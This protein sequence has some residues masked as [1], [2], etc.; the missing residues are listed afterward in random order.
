MLTVLVTQIVM[1]ILICGL[2]ACARLLWHQ[3]RQL[4]SMATYNY[5]EDAIE[6]T[7]MGFLYFDSRDKLRKTNAMARQMLPAL[8]DDD[9][10]LNTVDAFLDFV[11]S[12]RYS[13]RFGNELQAS[14]YQEHVFTHDF[15]E[16]MAYED[17]IYLMQASHSQGAALVVFLTDV[18]DIRMRELR[19]QQT[20][21]LE[22]LGRLAGGVA[23]DFNNLISI[24]DGYAR[25]IEKSAY[26]DHD[27][28]TEYAQRIRKAAE[29]GAGLTKQMLL[30]GQHKMVE[31]EPIDLAEVLAQLGKLLEPILD[32][33][34]ILSLDFEEGV[35]V[36]CS[37]DAMTQILMN[38][39]IN[40]RD[41]MPDGGRIKVTT[42][43][44]N[45]KSMPAHFVGA[46]KGR[47][48]VCI[49]VADNGTGITEQVKRRMFE[50]FFT[51]KSQ[52]QGAG[53]GLSM[54][55]GLVK[56]MSGFI[57]VETEEGKGTTLRLY[58]PVCVSKRKTTAREDTDGNETYRFDGYTV[59]LA[60]DEPDLRALTQV[61]LEE[62]GFAVLMAENGNQ[63]LVKQD[64]FDD[65][66]AFLI[67]DV[68]MP[69]LNGIQL[70][71]LFSAI[72]PETRI[73]YLSAFPANG[74]LSKLE[75]PEGSNLLPKPVDIC[76]L[77]KLMHDLLN[78]SGDA[79]HN[80]YGEDDSWAS[81]YQ[82]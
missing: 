4:S 16:A 37:H 24:V 27:K 42:K 41:A 14:S 43:T 62:M 68:V 66:I 59:M 13:K 79:F 8:K 11:F 55:Y 1:L 28:V 75:I 48:Y 67:T 50:P 17:R 76:K 63:A 40:A 31:V 69:E 23:H 56:E 2:A 22:A 70:A 54:I 61:A 38:L 60:E 51:T 25:M 7:P 30:F 32:K 10:S 44:V 46:N 49:S 80:N 39:V 73:I 33:S 6:S 65:D 64:D 15:M 20:Q 21:K 3:K 77:G 71:D 52:G 78:D 58:L 18:T 53:L 47:N 29:R 72:R 81:S 82:G 19:F 57:D 26:E 5:L 9:C 45:Q 34:I 12:N 74:A 36:N 35:R